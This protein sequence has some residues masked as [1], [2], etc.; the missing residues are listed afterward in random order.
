M[1]IGNI[2]LRASTTAVTN[3]RSNVDATI[4]VKS[5]PLTHEEVDLNF[6][7]VVEAH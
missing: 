6:L 2:K 3:L 4:T 7:E 5:S 1:A